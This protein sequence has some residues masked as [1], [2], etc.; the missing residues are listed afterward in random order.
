MQP[1]EATEPVVVREPDALKGARPVLRGESSREAW[2]LPSSVTPIQALQA[3]SHAARSSQAA[4]P[5]RLLVAGATGVL[6]NEVMRRLVG[7]QRY[8]LTQVLAREPITQ[9]LRTV[10]A[11]VVAGDAAAWPDAPAD[12]FDADASTGLI[13][14]DPPRLYYDRERAL[15]T[16]RP[17]QLLAVAQWMRRSGVRTLA[18][19]LP[20]AQGRLPDA[21][22]RGLAGMDEHAVVALGFER[23]LI[24]RSAQKGATNAAEGFL[25]KTAAWML[26]IVSFMVPSSEQP[27]RPSK[28]AEMVSEAL[29]LL[30]PGIHIAAPELVWQAAQG[31][32]RDVVA[33]WLAP[34]AA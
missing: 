6:G 3:A 30:P 11:L 34:G 5:Q 7:V 4:R 16:P 28:V 14:F 27:V 17:D 32:V 9:A 18:I 23:V 22:K 10:T 31:N 33:R 13:M 15:W 21:L 8:A 25:H 19:V 1:N 12:G 2:F 24:V 20:H 29:R 26:S